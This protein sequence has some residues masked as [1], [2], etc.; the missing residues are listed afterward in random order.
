MNKYFILIGI[1]VIGIVV[2]MFSVYSRLEKSVVQENIFPVMK[3]M[4]KLHIGRDDMIQVIPFKNNTYSTAFVAR[5]KAGHDS[6][7]QYMEELG[8]KF[9][10]QLGSSLSFK[11]NDKHVNVGYQQIITK[12]YILIEVPSLE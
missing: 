4:V 3:A 5:T 11:K 10:E 8:W 2:S 6:I 1:L 7:T 9:G 12:Y